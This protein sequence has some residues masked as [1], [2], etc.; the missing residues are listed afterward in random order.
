MID[1]KEDSPP[2]PYAGG[3]TPSFW[4]TFKFYIGLLTTAIVFTAWTT[5]LVAKPLATA[6][7]G[8]VT[9][10]GMS[11]AY[12]NYTRHKREERLASW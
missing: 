2:S 12:F 5:N 1:R 10:V 8:T 7:G 4:H 9:I 11:V 6:F 3:T